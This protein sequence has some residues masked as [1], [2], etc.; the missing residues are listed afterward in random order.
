MSDLYPCNTNK[1]RAASLTGEGIAVGKIRKALLSVTLRGYSRGLNKSLKLSS[2][3][4]LHE[5]FL[6]G[7]CLS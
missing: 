3:R 4:T 6:M 1:L 7:N 2:L 5:Q